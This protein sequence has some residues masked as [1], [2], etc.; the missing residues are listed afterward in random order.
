MANSVIWQGSGSFN[1][2][3]S[4]PFGFYDSDFSFG[5]DVLKVAKFCAARLGYPSMDIE[6]GMDQFATC[7]EEAVTTY[8]NEVY[9]YQIRNN[10]LSLEAS[11]TGSSINNAYIQPSLSGI[12]KIASDYGAEV[13]VGGNVDWYSGSIP[14]F[15]GQQDYDLNLWASG[16]ASL[17]AGDSIEVK[18]VFYENVPAIQRY[19]DPFVG[20][21]Y[22]TQNILDSFGFGA[23]S[24]AI[25]FMLMPLNFD[26]AVMQAIELNDTIRKSG[27]SFEI[28]NNKLKIFPIPTRDYDLRIRYVKNSEKNGISPTSGPGS[29]NGLVTNMSN[30]PYNNPV[31]S[32]INGP[33]RY[34]IFEYTVALAKEMLGLIR[35]KYQVVPV[36]GDSISLNQQDLLSQALSEKTSLLEKLRGDLD[37][38]SRKAQLQRRSDENTAM[39]NT[40]QGV[41]LQIW[42]G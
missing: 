35:G 36:P 40:L 5:S 12:I 27:F 8:G 15:A 9:L 20:T 14:M 18:Q 23:Q 25:N 37:E 31:Y 33:G 17:S 42:I 2:G 32:Q 19:F 13:G 26:M 10:Y 3:S 30:V 22:G 28:I 11:S 29:G 39:Q 7:F 38:T 6:M 21:G 41:P 24:P 16:S 4:T 1:S 34:W